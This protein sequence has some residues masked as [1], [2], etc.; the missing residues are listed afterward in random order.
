M[1]A[2]YVRF[3]EDGKTFLHTIFLKLIDLDKQIYTRNLYI[4]MFSYYILL[5]QQR[6]NI[7]IEKVI[8]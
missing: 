2:I 6:K 5:Y 1:S 7:K 8:F 4:L 3:L